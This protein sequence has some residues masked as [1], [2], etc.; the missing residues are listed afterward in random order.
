M[1]YSSKRRWGRMLTGSQDPV[2]AN[3]VP[4]H[5]ILRMRGRPA[6]F[7]SNARSGTTA[8]DA[9]AEKL[10]LPMLRMGD[11]AADQ[12]SVG[13]R[14]WAQGLQAYRLKDRDLCLSDG[15]TNTL[16]AKGETSCAR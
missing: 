16:S 3:I 12:F 10:W 9:A 13:Q 11:F 6:R 8:R 5:L 7:R 1:R 4:A 15:R 14:R 2:S